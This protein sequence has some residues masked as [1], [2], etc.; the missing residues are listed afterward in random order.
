[1]DWMH[2]QSCFFFSY[3]KVPFFSQSV[4]V[5]NPRYRRSRSA[6]IMVDHQSANIVPTNTVMQ[7]TNMKK[8]RSVTRL[9][10][11]DLLDPK[12]SN[13]ALTTQ[14]QDSDGDIVTKVY[15]V[16]KLRSAW[17]SAEQVLNF[18]M[19]QADVNP[20]SSGG[21]QVI[22]NDVEVLTQ[23]SPEK[24]PIRTRRSKRSFEDLEAATVG[25]RV[26]AFEHKLGSAKKYRFRWNTSSLAFLSPKDFTLKSFLF[27]MP[28]NYFCSE[29]TLLVFDR[30]SA[31][32]RS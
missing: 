11:K 1:M 8:K 23:K 29:N 27:T 3:K 21:R 26:A 17:L 28:Y 22:I 31:G 24:S 6:G 32:Q 7:P 15:K 14:E 25:S 13:Y 30:E 20:T 12:C 2:F 19:L 4:A 10:E 5:S 9:S 16:H 18:S